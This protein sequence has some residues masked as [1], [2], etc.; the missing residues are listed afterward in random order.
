MFSVRGDEWYKW[1][2]ANRWPDVKGLESY[3]SELIDEGHN[4][5][6][7]MTNLVAEWGINWRKATLRHRH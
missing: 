3:A 7:R 2:D 5:C 4:F 1:E 6:L